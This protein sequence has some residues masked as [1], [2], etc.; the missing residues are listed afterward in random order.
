MMKAMLVRFPPGEPVFTGRPFT[1]DILAEVD[2]RL[3]GG[4]LQEGWLEIESH[5]ARLVCL[6][7]Q[8]RSYLAGL[9]DPEGFSSVPLID[10]PARA[11]QF[12]EARVSLATADPI[13]VFLLAVHFR[14]RPA[15]QATTDLVDLQ[16]VFDVLIANGQDAALALERDGVRT[17]LFMQHGRPAR[18]FF[19]DPTSEPADETVAERFL[20][21]AFA[22]GAHVT[23]IEVFK[24]LTIDPDPDAG[25]TL[26]QLCAEAKPA[27]AKIITVKLGG[28]MVFLRPFMPP[29]MFIGR[30][31]SCEIFLDNLSVSRRHAR[32]VWERGAF[33]IED[34]DSA[35]GTLVGGEPVARAQ[36]SDNKPVG[37]GKF[38]LF[39][40]DPAS[41]SPE[42]T[43]L[44]KD[45]HESFAA[46]LYLVGEDQTIPL[47]GE[48]TIGQTHGVDVRARGFWINPI[49]AL[50][51]PKGPSIYQLIC[52]GRGSVKLNGRK[53]AKA[54]IRAGDELV[55]GRSRFRVMVHPN[56]EPSD[57]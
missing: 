5:E 44:L 2:A 4:G 46:D 34:L 26:G 32:L 16:H 50:L 12:E 23:K 40:R 47:R 54:V 21:F 52:H 42:P 43:V 13:R 6:F 29:G 24:R 39:L 25:K 55:V 33:V 41:V 38:Q 3:T 14:N 51:K 9:T 22:P 18:V 49:H 31:P 11:L 36:L 35:N 30:D 48:L 19:G 17:L 28:R 15:L 7:H 10:F 27:P 20:S 56:D 53:I 45:A 1:P 57:A 37:L 8:A